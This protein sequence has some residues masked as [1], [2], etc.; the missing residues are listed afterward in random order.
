MPA[1]A[2]AA[3]FQI[4]E[5]AYNG[6]GVMINSRFL[7]AMT[8]QAAFDE[9]ANRLEKQTIGNRAQ[10]ERKVQF[11]LRDW[12]ISRQRYWG[13]PI[14]MIHCEACGIVPVPKQ[15]L[16][17]ILPEDVTFDRPGNPLDHHPSWK[18]V[19]CPQC[20]KDARRETDTMD[21]F[22]DSS[23]YFA[24]FTA[25]WEKNP[26]DPKAA[27]DWLP[28]D[29]YIGGI[30]HAI[31]HLLYSRFF[32]RAMRATG[33]IDL[34]EPFK[35][36]F[37]Q[38]MV[39]HETYRAGTGPNA[40]WL[41]PSDVR[42]E[43]M[44]DGKR[45]AIEIAT[46]A[47]VEIGSLEKMSK[48]KK[49]TIGPEEITASYGADTA[50]WFMLSDSPPERDV[51]WTDSGADGAHRFVQRI[52]R[53]VSGAA[54]SVAPGDASKAEGA[55]LDMRRAAHKALKAV[56]EDFDRL[57]FNKAIARVHE[58]V[59]AIAAP[60]EAA[61]SGSASDKA[62]AHEALSILTQLFAPVMPHLAEECWAALGHE[63]MAAQAGWPAY[64]PALVTDNEIILPVQINGKKRG[65][66]TIA[67]D[68]GKEEVE[69]ATL[70]LDFVQK[71]LE[72]AKPK[73][74]VVVAQRIVNVVV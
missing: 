15:D 50:R 4:T 36:L 61:A 21:T 8:P 17:V 45:R 34:D 11:R 73:K 43:A 25:P 9:V 29:Q 30:E 5:T 49:N 14:P 31:L 51:E 40:Y 59:N 32:T 6:D 60:V 64:D 37:T 38:G 2:D 53:V 20:G 1:D 23:W 7:D 58:L 19:A 68:A 41:S 56:G 48:S 28:V 63:G 65:D 72:G 70:A 62:A 67:R 39:V 24:R 74:I 16:P 35:G 26:T 54:G 42:I 55:A 18:H 3:T 10:G 46:G 13:C 44:G 57:A 69:K 12:G 71:A 52:W 66:L 22:V 27:N 47:E 33:H